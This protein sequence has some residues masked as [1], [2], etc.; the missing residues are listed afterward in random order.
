METTKENSVRSQ[1]QDRTEE[2]EERKL[3]PNTT[4]TTMTTTSEEQC[5][6]CYKLG[7]TKQYTNEHE[8]DELCF[9]LIP[10]L[11]GDERVNVKLYDFVSRCIQSFRNVI[12]VHTR[13]RLSDSRKMQMNIRIQYLRA[14][15]YITV[16]YMY[17]YMY[18]HIYICTY[19]YIIN[20]TTPLL[21]C[22]RRPTIIQTSLQ[23][24][25]GSFNQTNDINA[26]TLQTNENQRIIVRLT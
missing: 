12:H 20:Q 14:V 21:Q 9:R 1:E 2:E 18:M 19:T 15:S 26:F 16:L 17:M 24:Q 6:Q 10:V 22:Q 5:Y 7:K 11:R 8:N 3:E 25:S 13:R 4:T 23:Q